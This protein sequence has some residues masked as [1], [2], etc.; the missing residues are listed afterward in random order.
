ML[1]IACFAQLGAEGLNLHSN[2][3]GNCNW[4]IGASDLDK[5]NLKRGENRLT[6]AEKHE[7]GGGR[8]KNPIYFVELNDGSARGHIGIHYFIRILYKGYGMHFQ[9]NRN[10]GKAFHVPENAATHDTYLLI[11]ILVLQHL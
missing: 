2:T 3:H 5:I 8:G 10:G 4:V 9:H 11:F 1:C 7:S 6:F